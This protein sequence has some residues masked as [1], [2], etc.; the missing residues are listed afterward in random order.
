MPAHVKALV[1]D[2]SS[3]GAT[4]FVEPLQVVEMN[5]RWRELQL[6]EHDEEKR[7]LL[8]LSALVDE[9]ANESTRSCGAWQPWT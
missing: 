2:R 3:S 9:H 5:N 4:L 6:A 1:H 8:E 7:I